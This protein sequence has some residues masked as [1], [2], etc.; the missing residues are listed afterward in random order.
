MP[1]W[2]R[3]TASDRRFALSVARS[4]HKQLFFVEVDWDDKPLR[5][6]MDDVYQFNEIDGAG[7]MAYELPTYAHPVTLW[8]S[9]NHVHAHRGVQIMVTKC[10]SPSCVADKGCY[11]PRCPYNINPVSLP[12]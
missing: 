7:A 11:S 3:T 1:D 8:D 5:D 9:T 2:T 12:V 10:Y 4:L 6:A